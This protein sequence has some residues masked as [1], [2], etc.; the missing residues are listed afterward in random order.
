MTGLVFYKNWGVA[1]NYARR[2]GIT[3]LPLFTATV[4]ANTDL[5]TAILCGSA[6]SAIALATFIKPRP[7]PSAGR[8]LYRTDQYIIANLA[9]LTRLDA[10]HSAVLFTMSLDEFDDWAQRHDPA[11]VRRVISK[12]YDRL[13]QVLRQD[14][15]LLHAD[16]HRFYAGFLIANQPNANTLIAIARRLQRAID[17]AYFIGDTPHYFSLSVGFATTDHP[18]I[19]SPKDMMRAGRV[20]LATANRVGHGAVRMFA[21]DMTEAKPVAAH[22]TSPML[23][24]A[25]QNG[26]II[27]YFQPQICAHS[28]QVIGV[29]AL[30]RWQQPDGSFVAP[31]DFLP[32][33]ESA[34]L[35]RQATSQILNCA[36][37]ARRIWAE[38]GCHIAT[39]SVNLSTDDLSDPRLADQIGWHLRRHKLQASVLRLEVVENVIIKNTDDIISKNIHALVAMGCQID[40][41]DFGTGHASIPSLRHAGLRRLKID[42]SFVTHCDT[43]PKQ[44]R[45]LSAIVA[46]AQELDLKIVAE[47]VETIGEQCEVIRQG[48]DVIQGYVIARPMPGHEIPKWVEK[49]HS[50]AGHAREIG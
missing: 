20:A 25:L 9:S 16:D 28:N 21:N 31:N 13:A 6:C 24:Q 7:Y 49:Y 11:M 32:V 23:A 18:A 12:T 8:Q 2:I 3:G 29:E 1:R 41:D 22:P 43:D 26:D 44:K 33:L 17:A 40:L 45:L 46:M 50:L 14:T 42:R 48:A 39:V 30:A 10:P 37:H 35:M 15:L 4:A 19:S 5:S 36:L 47:G 38:R 34:G 27:P